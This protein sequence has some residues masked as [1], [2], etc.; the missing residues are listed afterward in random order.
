MF[1]KAISTIFLLLLSLISYSSDYY[2][3]RDSGDWSDINHWA[4]TSGG[5]IHHIKTPT[6]SDDVYF[7]SNSTS[8]NLTIN[9]NIDLNASENCKEPITIKS[10]SSFASFSKNSGTISCSYLILEHIHAISG[11]IF[12]T[13]GSRDLGDNIGWNLVTPAM[14]EQCDNNT[15]N[16]L[17]NNSD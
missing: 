15:Q 5:N 4:T 11:A 7:D 2:L 16:N 8:S 14:T 1:H 17:L 9:L 3:V 12:N 6:A 10:L 13:I